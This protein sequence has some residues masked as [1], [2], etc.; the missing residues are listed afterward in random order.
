M[1]NYSRCL[2]VLLAV[3]GSVVFVIFRSS[4][5]PNLPVVDE[6]ME[7]QRLSQ[8]SPQVI[9][10]DDVA[11]P[12]PVVQLQQTMAAGLVKL[13]DPSL[14]LIQGDLQDFSDENIDETY[15]P[16]L[17]LSDLESRLEQL[18]QLHKSLKE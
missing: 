11:F 14:E 17:E 4:G 7:E 10:S 12:S 9:L 3:I 6:I 15:Q 13:A 18:K 16:P 1:N 2:L 5:T 8:R